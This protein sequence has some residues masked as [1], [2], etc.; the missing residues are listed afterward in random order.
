MTYARLQ[1]LPL[2]PPLLA[3]AVGV[4][5]GPEVLGVLDLSEEQ[6]PHL[7]VEATRFLLAVSVMGVALVRPVG[8]GVRRLIGRRGLRP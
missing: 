8:R 3:L 1:R 5:F 7:L 6:R 2:S 4:L